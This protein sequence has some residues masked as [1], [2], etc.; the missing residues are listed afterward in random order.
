MS[1]R[2]ENG[3]PAEHVPRV[4]VLI[5]AYNAVPYV[6][7][8]IQSVLD[9]SFADFELLVVDD[10]STDETPAVLERFAQL[11][12]RVRVLRMQVNS[13]PVM[14]ANKGLAEVRAPLLARLDADDVC[15]ADRLSQQVEAFDR[16]PELVLLGSA[17]DYIDAA[18]QPIAQGN[19]PTDDATLQ[20]V[21][22]ESGNPFCHPSIMMR[23]DALRS[24]GGYRQVLNPY[25]LDYDLCLRMAELGRIGNLPERLI[26]YRIHAGQITVTKMKPQLR[27]AQI[28]RA[29]ARLR[30]TGRPED[31]AVAQADPAETPAG[32]R[33][34]LVHGS[35]FWADLLDRVGAT[36]RARQLRWNAVRVAP[37]HPLVRRMAWARLKHALQGRGAA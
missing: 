36:E 23:T 34:T 28:Y 6:T 37:W 7:E 29:L 21:L 20:T 14:A 17:F 31:V 33:Q 35:I 16:E 5:A 3:M 32:L 8:A 12:P 4:C 25:G 13:G 26:G 24:L 27:S 1:A 11:D 10:A 18:G 15:R 30:R 19:P 2:L 9:Q 22:M